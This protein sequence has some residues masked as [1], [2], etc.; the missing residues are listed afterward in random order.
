VAGGEEGAYDTGMS[1]KAWRNRWVLR[2]PLNVSSLELNLNHF[3]FSI[4]ILQYFIIDKG[5]INVVTI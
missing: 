4:S 5:F 2:L 3:F 1:A